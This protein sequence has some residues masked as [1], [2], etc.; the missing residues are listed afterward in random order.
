MIPQILYLCLVSMKQY[1]I[2]AFVCEQFY[3]EAN[4]WVIF[5]KMKTFAFD[6]DFKKKILSEWS[7]YSFI[8]MYLRLNIN[9][10]C[11]FSATKGYPHLKPYR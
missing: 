10:L 9:K 3:R 8:C 1:L 6:L 11:N 4:F 7:Y 2:L 5:L